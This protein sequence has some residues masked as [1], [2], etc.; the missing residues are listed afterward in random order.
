GGGRGKGKGRAE[1]WEE[2]GGGPR[3]RMPPPD[4]RAA[5]TGPAR[6]RAARTDSASGRGIRTD[7][8]RERAGRWDRPPCHRADRPPPHRCRR[9][10]KSTR[11]NSSH[12]KTSYAVFCLK[13]KKQSA[14][15]THDHA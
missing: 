5:R 11:L 8:V 10:R 3:E 12:V 2:G 4:T 14:T 9:D 7:P 6:E 1:G 15:A 13:R